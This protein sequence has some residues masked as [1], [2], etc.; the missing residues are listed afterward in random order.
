MEN[1]RPQIYKTR[2]GVQQYRIVFS[3][4]GT[5]ADDLNKTSP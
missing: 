5:V 3:E 1:L 2:R 4:T